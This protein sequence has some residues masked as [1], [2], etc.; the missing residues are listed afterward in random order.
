V[1]QLKIGHVGTERFS[2]RE[3]DSIQGGCLGTAVAE[4]ATILGHRRIIEKM[5]S[6]LRNKV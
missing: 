6:D 1:K 3:R 5:T 4:A 2:G